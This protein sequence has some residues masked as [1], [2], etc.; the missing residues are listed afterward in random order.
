MFITGVS[1]N[2]HSYYSRVHE[3]DERETVSMYIVSQF[4]NSLRG[5]KENK[6]SIYAQRHDTTRR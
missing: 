5:K 6:V 3:F 4:L 2:C 1:I